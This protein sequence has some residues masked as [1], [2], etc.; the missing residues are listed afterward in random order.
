MISTFAYIISFIDY[1]GFI[2][3]V[4]EVFIKKIFYEHIFN[5]I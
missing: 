1:A 2:I 4:Q 3:T 5:V